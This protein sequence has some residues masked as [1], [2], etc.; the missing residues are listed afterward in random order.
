MYRLLQKMNDVARRGAIQN[1]LRQEERLSLE[2]FIVSLK[3]HARPNARRFEKGQ[4]NDHSRKALLAVCDGVTNGP[5]SVARG[6]I[7]KS[8]EKGKVYGYYA[9]VA[10]N[11]LIFTTRIH[12]HLANAVRDHILLSRI[13]EEAQ[14][15]NA[16]TPF[17][18]KVRRAVTSVL[19]DEGTS[20]TDFF[21]S[22]A[23]CF[24]A[25]HWIGRSLSIHLDGLE[26]AL[27]A[28]QHIE[29]AQTPKLF[30]HGHATA[31]YS[32]HRA[33]QQWQQL[34]QVFVEFSVR[35]GARRQHDVEARLALMETAHRTRF[36]QNTAKRQREKDVMAFSAKCPKK[37]DPERAVIRRF[38]CALQVWRCD[39]ARMQRQKYLSEKR[40]RN[41]CA[42]LLKKRRWDGKESVE[43]FKR[44]IANQL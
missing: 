31:A 8:A 6:G 16:N 38:R 2:A 10:F 39:T 19:A 41:A 33:V 18:L 21:R 29:L 15:E 1:S 37:I 23:V 22:V 13:I 24:S 43:A 35:N 11:R 9:K 26:V 20:D 30:L 28:W 44:R 7:Y 3:K 42:E 25:Q 32:S 5:Q 14:R 27:Q 12:V 17:V 34:K 4:V 36:I 40:K